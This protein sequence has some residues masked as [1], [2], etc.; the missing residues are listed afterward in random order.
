MSTLSS[1]TAAKAVKSGSL[2]AG[3]EF[4]MVSTE[5]GISCAAARGDRFASASHASTTAPRSA[6]VALW[7]S[8][9]F[10][11]F[12]SH[13]ATASSRASPDA[14]KT[15]AGQSSYSHTRAAPRTGQ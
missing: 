1:P 2:V 14:S 5:Y 15:E 10:K 7:L 12:G 3:A 8:V 6:L 13:E 9:R 4:V 11:A